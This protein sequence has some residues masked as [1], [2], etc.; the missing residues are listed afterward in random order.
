MPETLPFS[1][2]FLCTNISFYCMWLVFEI[3]SHTLPQA[4]LELRVDVHAG[5]EL[6]E[7]PILLPQPFKC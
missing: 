4:S 6:N 2:P 3:G 7:I 1:Q 5:L